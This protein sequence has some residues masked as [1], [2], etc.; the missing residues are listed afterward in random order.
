LIIHTRWQEAV[1]V[2]G[3]RGLRGIRAY[4][5]SSRS[6]L[7]IHTRWQEAIRAAQGGEGCQGYTRVY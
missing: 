1:S 4:T 2:G 5:T 3:E 6:M 7:I